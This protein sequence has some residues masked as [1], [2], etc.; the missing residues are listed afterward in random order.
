MSPIAQALAAGDTAALTATLRTDLLANQ[1]AI[2][3]ALKQRKAW[4]VWRVSS[5]EPARNKFGKVPVYPASG[6][7]RCGT[8]GSPEDLA[9]LGTWEQALAAFQSDPSLAGVGVAMLPES[10][11]VALDADHCLAPASG[12]PALP[13]AVRDLCGAT[14]TEISPSGTG[15]RAF[16]LGTA[17]D[18][19]NHG[20]G[21][22][23][24]HGKGFV[25]V[26]GNRLSGDSV[27]ALTTDHA[28]RLQAKVQAR[29]PAT[30][31]ER[32]EQTALARLTEEA[33][34]RGM[35]PQVREALF[36]IPAD[37]YETWIAM[38][39]AL[40]TLGDPAE[41]LWHDWSAT[42]AKYD[43]VDA[44]QRWQSFN[45]TQTGPGAI[46]VEARR[47]GWAGGIP[48]T[49]ERAAN[50]DPVP[51]D[52]AALPLVPP[53]VP[54][55]IPG[56]LP[57][58]VVTLFASHGG[59]GKSYISF[60]IAICLA[61]GWHPFEAG[62][63]LPRQRVLFYS[64]EDG[65]AALQSRLRSY[66]NL[67]GVDT[68]DLEGWLLPFDASASD[69]VLFRAGRRG[70]GTMPRHD[71]IADKVE[72][73]GADLLIF[74]N[75]S[76]AMDANENDRA[77][78]RQFMWALRNLAPTV[79]LLAHVD[80]ASSM[81]RPGEAKGYSGSTAWHN[82]A[83]SRWLVTR[84]SSGALLLQLAKSNY[85]RAGAEVLLRW[86]DTHR[87]FT[88]KGSYAQAPGGEAHRPLLLAL[89]SDALAEGVTI[90]PHANANNNL[91]RS[92]CYRRDFPARLDSK[93]VF[94][95][96]AEWRRVGLVRVEDHRRKS[97]QT[98]QRLA[99]TEAGRAM[100]NRAAGGKTP[101]REIHPAEEEMEF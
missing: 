34:A 96:L 4:L 2:P 100:A 90:S 31:P 1:Q 28:A 35:L 63:R 8:Q 58:G 88:V 73:F 14:Y 41:S 85:A 20:E 30:S 56:W 89:L 3:D 92:I 91:F 74:D 68:A 17:V 29:A 61:L 27:E 25:T 24:F 72:A 82:S 7:N 39:H 5:I 13:E 21:V 55:L 19:K 71:W 47:H 77:A 66:L 67:M 79:L 83:R 64:A 97:R 101:K 62:Q 6:R 33:N 78:V 48:A 52:L 42:S 51:L 49:P 80:A 9:G 23:L 16:W 18:G 57:A 99:L 36:A 40:K 84:D 38:G 86:D 70:A 81:A 43:P 53:P 54:F 65:M 50:R 46:F 44:Q 95:E 59:V 98:G 12:T 11:I 87:V 32:P 15:I 76:E 60:Y 93:A 10:G 45:P 75:A 26:T 94:R 37:D 69:N 22:E